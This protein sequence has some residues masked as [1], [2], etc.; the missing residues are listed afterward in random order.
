[1][2]ELGRS[3]RSEASRLVWA[4][5]PV[6]TVS[7][8][9]SV[10]RPY[11]RRE[12]PPRAPLLTPTCYLAERPASTRLCVRAYRCTL[13]QRSERV[14][15][16]AASS[17]AGVERPGAGCATSRDLRSPLSRR[18]PVG[19]ATSDVGRA[20]DDR[21]YSRLHERLRFSQCTASVSSSATNDCGALTQCSATG[22]RR[23]TQHLIV[24][25]CQL[26]GTARNIS[27]SV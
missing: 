4:A 5:G 19:Q 24:R 9:D 6:P 26:E 12:A 11:L 17:A 15:R 13:V 23:P 7:V 16:R 27:S 2:G 25:D 10:R 3:R 20:A 18:G 14:A 21:L 1:M 8:R 22:L